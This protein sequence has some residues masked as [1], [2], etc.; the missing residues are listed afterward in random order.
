MDKRLNV[1]HIVLGLSIIIIILLS[2]S[3]YMIPQ[4]EAVVSMRLGRTAQST[5]QAGIHW[6]LPWPL[7]KIE[8]ID[9]RKRNV[10]S[11]H[12][13]MLTRDNRNI[14]VLSFVLWSVEDPL[15]FYQAV[16]SQEEGDA[17]IDGLLTNAKIS[18]MGGYDLSAL[19]SVDS[20]AQKYDEIE[21]KLRALIEEVSLNRYG[22]RVHDVGISRLS[23]PKEN[24]QAV[25]KQMRAERK[26]YA[27]AFKAEG[28]KRADEIRAKT[29]VEVAKIKAK[30]MTK[31]SKIRGDAEA[32]AAQIYADAYKKDPDLYRFIR[33]LDSLEKVLG[34]KSSVIL[35]TDADP[36]RLLQESR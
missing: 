6:R 28:A 8:R 26:Q 2:S 34:T 18:I 17:K 22:I 15:L 24:I 9:M 16:G 36:F 11:K 33:E 29:D 23:L 4:G 13:E 7:E 12:T 21:S 19:A 20:D 27:A 30:A 3:L 14:I 1:L 10:R 31:A 25:F 5:T 35:R 32:Q